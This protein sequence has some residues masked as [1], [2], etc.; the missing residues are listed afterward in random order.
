MGG[1]EGRNALIKLR[2][3]VTGLLEASKVETDFL[4]TAAD[5]MDALQEKSILEPGQEMDSIK[6]DSLLTEFEDLLT[7]KKMWPGR[8]T[9]N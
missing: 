5:A 7:L 8:R 4:M 6:L 1:G 3:Q 2:K 9:L